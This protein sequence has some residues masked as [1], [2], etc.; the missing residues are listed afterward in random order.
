MMYGQMTQE[1]IL[2]IQTRPIGLPRH[3]EPQDQVS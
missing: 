2:W 3:S 1:Q